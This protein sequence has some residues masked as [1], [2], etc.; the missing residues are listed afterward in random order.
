MKRPAFSFLTWVVLILV[1]ATLCLGFI[2]YAEV[3]QNLRPGQNEGFAS[4]GGLAHALDILYRTLGLFGLSGINTYNNPCL[5]V[6]RWTGALFSFFIVVKLLTP[7]L[8][9]GLLRLRLLRYRRHTVV[10]G[11]G[12]KGKGF[13]R[14][15]LTRGRVVGVDRVLPSLES[16]EPGPTRRPLLVSGD[17][18]EDAVLRKVGADRA[19]RVIIATPDDL[20]NLSIAKAV[21]RSVSDAGGSPLDLVVHIADPTLRVEGVS[22]IPLRTGLQLRPFSIPALAA[23]QLHAARPFSALARLLGARQVHLVLVGFNAHSEELITQ[24]ARIGPSRDQDLAL[25]TIFTEQPAALREQ[26]LRRY[27][28]LP[29]LLGLLNVRELPSAADFIEDDLIQVEGLSRDRRVTGI[30]VSAR[31]DTEAIVRAR[32]LRTAK[33]SHGRWLAPIYVQLE[34]PVVAEQSVSPFAS[35]KRLSQVI[36]P[37]GEIR[38]LCSEQGL[39]TWHEALAQRLHDSY[40][41]APNLRAE[42]GTTA[43]RSWH[44]LR[45]EYRESNRRAVDHLHVTLDSLGYINRGE[46]PLLARPPSLAPSEQEVVERLEHASWS[47]SMKLAGWR[48]GPQ[49]DEGRKLHEELVPFDELPR[50]PREVLH[51]QLGRLDL[52]LRPVDAGS[53]NGKPER[54]TVFRERVIGLV[55]H[56]ILSSDQARIVQ[57][58][59][60]QLLRDMQAPERL[61]PGGEEF[62][63]LVTPLAPGADLILARALCEALPNASR[64]RLIVV[65]CASVKALVDAYLGQDPSADSTPDGRGTERDASRLETLINDFVDASCESVVEI[66]AAPSDGSATML[67]SAFAALDGYLLDRCEEL[68]AVFDGSRYGIPGP[69]D[70]DVWRSQG[71]G[72]SPPHGTGQLLYS[73]LNRRTA[74][75]RRVPAIGAT[76]LWVLSPREAVMDETKTHHVEWTKG[77]APAVEAEAATPRPG[78]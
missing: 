4:A 39:Q 55:G 49:R 25:V 19:S 20:A 43:A 12:E 72:R 59:V 74:S 58:A 62:W 44:E 54:P 26:L 53:L 3:A 8:E 48:L 69:F 21:A 22:E 47:A 76:G 41:T 33:T 78:P 68:V 75:S 32:R 65:R 64:Y 38:D 18:E 30:V 27:P 42:P 6:G 34:R 13:V 1:V 28:T 37:F 77:A 46:R 60:P 61:G 2:G 11:L 36:Q 45:E 29:S 9:A 35:T 7:R 5:I 66:P 10:I 15:A 40:L 23:R 63:T 50:R 57:V 14:D 73:W 52:L 70:A 51:A 56:N 17:A 67:D 31:S 24:L 16:L 71:A